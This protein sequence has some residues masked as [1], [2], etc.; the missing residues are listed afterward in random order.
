[1]GDGH[2]L[3][4]DKRLGVPQA[5]LEGW[6]Q[7]F[8]LERYTT[9]LLDI[10]DV[11][12]FVDEEGFLVGGA[13]CACVGLSE[14]NPGCG[15]AFER[16]SQFAYLAVSQRVSVKPCSRVLSQVSSTLMPE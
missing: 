9:D 11:I 2:T 10:K 1:V 12:G 4:R 14:Q 8:G 3:R 13:R 5:C 7:F 6:G 16:S 15:L